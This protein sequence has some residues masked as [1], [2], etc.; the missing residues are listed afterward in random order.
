MSDFMDAAVDDVTSTL[1]LMMGF[2]PTAGGG[3][4]LVDGVAVNPPVGGVGV[5][6]S[7]TRVR[8]GQTFYLVSDVTS[9]LSREQGRHYMA[10]LDHGVDLL[11]INPAIALSTP[12][13]TAAFRAGQDI[14]SVSQH[15]ARMVAGGAL[16]I[17]PENHYRTGNPDGLYFW[18]FHSGDPVHIRAHSFYS[19]GIPGEGV[20][21]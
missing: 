6:Q 3:T 12:E 1:L 21:P 5:A 2:G 9:Q 18:H 11:F 15:D 4:V 20:F 7:N 17:G 19:F 8:N 14:W 13:A 16:A 10:Y